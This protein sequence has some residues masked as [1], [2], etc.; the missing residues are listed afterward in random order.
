MSES[1]GRRKTNHRL[2]LHYYEGDANFF[3]KIIHLLIVSSIILIKLTIDFVV[4]L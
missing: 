3:I 4:L 1:V 2:D